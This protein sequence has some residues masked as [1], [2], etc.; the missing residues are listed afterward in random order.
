[1]GSLDER[2]RGIGVQNA[3]SAQPLD[4]KPVSPWRASSCMV[5]LYFAAGAGPATRRGAHASA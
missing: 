3:A 4:F 1:M 2:A 5:L